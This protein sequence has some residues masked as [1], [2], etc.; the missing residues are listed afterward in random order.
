MTKKLIPFSEV[1]KK[2]ESSLTPEQRKISKKRYQL[3]IEKLE[4]YIKT[5]NIPYTDDME[6]YAEWLKTP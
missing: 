2:F 6:K 5:V 4:A 1:R 3:R